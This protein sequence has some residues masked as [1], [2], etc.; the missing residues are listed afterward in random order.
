[1]SCIDMQSLLEEAEWFLGQPDSI[2]TILIILTYQNKEQIRQK[3]MFSL[4]IKKSL[5][6]RP[7]ESILALSKKEMRATKFWVF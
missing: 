3:A 6:Q 5:S 2:I 4:E 1:M 7:A